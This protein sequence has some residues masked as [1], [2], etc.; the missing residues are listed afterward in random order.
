MSQLSL[1][2]IALSN[3]DF[4]FLKRDGKDSRQFIFIV[5]FASRYEDLTVFAVQLFITVSFG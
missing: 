5:I 3:R 4:S 2:Q 1:Q